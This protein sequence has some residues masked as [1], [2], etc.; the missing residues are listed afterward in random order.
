[1]LIPIR[2]RVTCQV[3]TKVALAYILQ[4]VEFFFQTLPLFLDGKP[5]EWGVHWAG[6]N[7]WL[8]W[9]DEQC[10]G[11]RLG[12]HNIDGPKSMKNWRLLLPLSTPIP[13]HMVSTGLSGLNNTRGILLSFLVKSWWE[14]FHWPSPRPMHETDRSKDRSRQWAGWRGSIPVP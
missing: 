12:L 10:H 7:M 2:N 3:L 11:S 6:I 1:M 14:K 13:C 5:L 4:I 9:M 8:W